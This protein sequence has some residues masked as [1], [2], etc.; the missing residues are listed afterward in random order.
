MRQY[1]LR[2][3]GMGA[4]SFTRK[5][6]AR[7]HLTSNRTGALTDSTACRNN[8]CVT[9]GNAPSS[10]GKVHCR[11]EHC[12]FG[13]KVFR[14]LGRGCQWHKPPRTARYKISERHLQHCDPSLKLIEGLGPDFC[15]DVRTRQLWNVKVWC[16]THLYYGEI[17]RASDRTEAMRAKNESDGLGMHVLLLVMYVLTILCYGRSVLDDTWVC[18]FPHRMLK[19]SSPGHHLVLG[20]CIEPVG[21]LPQIRCLL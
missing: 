1:A 13:V 19:S 17:N 15:R 9:H 20:T 14:W 6:C 8:L 18:L 10:N 2:F 11:D 4:V 21:Q 16:C 3:Q 5:S 12:L 7:A